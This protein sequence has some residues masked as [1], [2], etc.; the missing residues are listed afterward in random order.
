MK[1]LGKI[2]RASEDAGKE[3]LTVLK[4]IRARWQSFDARSFFSVEWDVSNDECRS[5]P[6][7]HL[8]QQTSCL[9]ASAVESIPC[10]SLAGIEK[11]EELLESFHR[12]SAAAHSSA[13]AALS[14]AAEAFLWEKGPCA[15]FSSFSCW[16]Q[17]EQDSLSS[18]PVR[19]LHPPSPLLSLPP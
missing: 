12:V 16:L 6:N 8:A 19:R 4:S 13:P 2:S 3:E 15:W 14:I 7:A 17:S 1:A 11:D 18:T 10:V 9:D 5:L